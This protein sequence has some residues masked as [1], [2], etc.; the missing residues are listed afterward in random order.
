ML[1]AWVSW[2]CSKVLFT[3][4]LSVLDLDLDRGSYEISPRPVFLKLMWTSLKQ[5]Y[6]FKDFSMWSN[7]EGFPPVPWIS[8]N[9]YQ[10]R[11]PVKDPDSGFLQT[12]IRSLIILKKSL[13]IICAC[14]KTDLNL[15]RVAAPT[16]RFIFIFSNNRFTN[17]GG[18]L[19]QSWL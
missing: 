2:S 13:F 6:R 19:D 5:F 15:R 9:R 16:N 1:S 8:D 11:I 18:M 4:V 12:R 3:F 14:R 17:S 10:L 7:T